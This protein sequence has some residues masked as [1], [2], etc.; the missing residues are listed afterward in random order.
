MLHAVELVKG[1]QGDP[2]AADLDE[3]W[4]EMKEAIDLDE[5]DD[6]DDEEEEDDIEDDDERLYDVCPDWTPAFLVT[7]PY[8]RD[9]SDAAQA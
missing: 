3:I 4:E 5:D 7:L 1:I 2:S 8:S 9:N 6:E